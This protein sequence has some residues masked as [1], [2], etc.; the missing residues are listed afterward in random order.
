[1]AWFLA[2]ELSNSADRPK[3]Q[4]LSISCQYATCFLSPLI[5]FPIYELYGGWSF[6]LFIGPLTFTS[7]YLYIY[8]PET[9]HRSIEDIVRDLGDENVNKIPKKVFCKMSDLR[10]KNITNEIY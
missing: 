1:M 5:F 6:L 9:K 3:I 4:S 10:E 2:T 7:I 8:L